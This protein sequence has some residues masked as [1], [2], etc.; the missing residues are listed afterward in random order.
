[1]LIF[2]YFDKNEKN[3]QEY[4]YSYVLSKNIYAQLFKNPN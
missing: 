2:T 1:M 3:L 4:K